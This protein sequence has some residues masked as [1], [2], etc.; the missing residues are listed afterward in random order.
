MKTIEQQ[1]DEV[2]EAL[3]KRAAMSRGAICLRSDL[4]DRHNK[5]LDL[6]DVSNPVTQAF[7]TQAYI[8]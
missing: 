3:A 5:A 1:M 8:Q 7:W 2:L 4:G 6:S